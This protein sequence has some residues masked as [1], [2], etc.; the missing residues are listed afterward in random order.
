MV[1]RYYER[2]KRTWKVH[3]KFVTNLVLFLLIWAITMTTLY[4]TQVLGNK[5]DSESKDNSTPT[6]S[7]D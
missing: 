1:D 3:P 5:D 6:F 7:L 4:L 2:K